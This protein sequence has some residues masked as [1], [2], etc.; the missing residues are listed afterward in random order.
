MQTDTQTGTQTDTQTGARTG[1]QTWKETGIVRLPGLLGATR[2]ARLEQEASE[3]ITGPTTLYERKGVTQQRDGSL[4]SP[5]HCQ[6]VDGGAA[7][8]A[9]LRD[10]DILGALR[11][12]TGYMRLFPTGGALVIY[13]RGDFQGLHTDSNKA[14]VT[15]VI[16]LTANLAP[17]GYAP[18]LRFDPSRKE[19]HAVRLAEAVTEQGIFPEGEEFAQLTHPHGEDLI[20]GFAGYDIPHWRPPHPHQEPGVIAT[21]GYMDL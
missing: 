12:A 2:L 21:L 15:V 6:M 17:M 5:A 13:N 11:E 1:T 20:Q 18:T 4:A 14:T 16:A 19:P 3:R 7:L 8:N 10:K 9:V